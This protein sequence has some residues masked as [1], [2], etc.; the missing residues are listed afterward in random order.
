MLLVGVVKSDEL[1][2]RDDPTPESL[3]GGCWDGHGV[4]GYDD[5]RLNQWGC[6]LPVV[7]AD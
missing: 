5:G 7:V 4:L 3:E 1:A 6:I 2:N